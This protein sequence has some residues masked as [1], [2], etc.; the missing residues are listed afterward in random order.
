[1]VGLLAYALDINPKFCWTFIHRKS[2]F[3]NIKITSWIIDLKDCPRNTFQAIWDC[4]IEF[5]HFNY[6]V[7]WWFE[8]LK[9]L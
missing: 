8:I 1:M 4:W 7:H 2:P 3:T 6:Q 5:A 9:E